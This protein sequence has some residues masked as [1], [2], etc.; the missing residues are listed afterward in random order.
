MKPLF[1][2]G[3]N[4]TCDNFFSWLISAKIFN[5]RNIVSLA[6]PA[7]TEGKFLLQQKKKQELHVTSIFALQWHF[8]DCVSMPAPQGP[9]CLAVLFIVTW[10]L[11]KNH[12]RRSLKLSC[13]TIRQKFALTCWSKWLTC[14][15]RKL[16]VESALCMYFY[17]VIFVSLTWLHQWLDSISSGDR[18]LHKPTEIARTFRRWQ[19]S[20][21]E[22]T[23]IK[24]HAGDLASHTKIRYYIVHVEKDFTTSTGQ[25]IT[26]LNVRNPSVANAGWNHVPHVEVA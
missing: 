12:S 8:F 4:A 22:K 19:K 21:R 1:N 15:R 2:M 18:I 3:Y 16:Q 14:I 26:I 10:I 7:K 23:Q 25:L 13:F 9:W 11:I 20:W 24:M 6:H 17:D 5:K